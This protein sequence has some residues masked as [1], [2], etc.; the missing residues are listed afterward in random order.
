MGDTRRADAVVR[1][2]KHPA[3]GPNQRRPRVFV[4]LAVRRDRPMS[5]W[6]PAARSTSPRLDHFE[7]LHPS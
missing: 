7:S 2:K 1:V 4:K 5:A 6:G 3:G